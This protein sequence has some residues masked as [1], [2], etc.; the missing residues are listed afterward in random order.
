M[1]FS[2][3]VL[4]IV[5]L[6]LIAATSIATPSGGGYYSYPEKAMDPETTF[7]NPSGPA[8]YVMPDLPYTVTISSAAVTLLSSVVSST[9]PQYCLVTA[10]DNFYLNGSQATPTLGIFY[11]KD[12]PHLIPNGV[13]VTF[14]TTSDTVSLKVLPVK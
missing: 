3:V 1:K 2:T 12:T 5:V 10:S 9:D 4:S 13:G 7:A 6:M 8:P 14:G 11:A